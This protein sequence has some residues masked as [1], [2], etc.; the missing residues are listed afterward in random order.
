MSGI[1]RF[2]VKMRRMIERWEEYATRIAE[3]ARKVLGD[4]RVYVFG[5][6]VE[7][8]WT[9]GSDVDILIV[10]SRAPRRVREIAE[11]KA[12]IEEE[13]GLPPIHPFEIH[14]VNEEEARWYFRH[15]RKYKE[16]L[17]RGHQ[18]GS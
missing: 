17:P 9:G 4:C 10:S 2:R 6:V 12:R 18:P 7:G 13:A 15:M 8:T 11:L 14:L 1:F 5:S 16:I 3:A